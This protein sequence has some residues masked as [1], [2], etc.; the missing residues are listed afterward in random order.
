MKTSTLHPPAP[1]WFLV[2]AEGKSPGRLASRIARLLRG[3]HKP[4]FSPHQMWGDHVVVVNAEKLSVS[5]GKLRRKV[6]RKHTGYPGHLKEWSM[7]KAL[8][9]R[10]EDVIERAVK[11]MLPQNRLRP[12]MLRHLHVFRGGDHPYAAQQPISL[13]PTKH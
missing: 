13:D 6:Y 2:D 1:Q 12:L 10:P 7:A 9:R 5:A 4:A 11:G 8:E 3:K